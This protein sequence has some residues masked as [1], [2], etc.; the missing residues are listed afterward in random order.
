MA[1]NPG[2]VGVSYDV[3]S[4]AGTLG[5][6]VVA[7]PDVVPDLDRLTELLSGALARLCA[8]RDFGNHEVPGPDRAVG[9]RTRQ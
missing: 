9:P 4:Y 3:L 5:V 2:N 8:L 7:D 1:V 6:T